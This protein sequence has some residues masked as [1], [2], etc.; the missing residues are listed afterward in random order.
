MGS[1][2]PFL[3]IPFVLFERVTLSIC[4]SL[5][6]AHKSLT[7]EGEQ[8]K[9]GGNRMTI[10]PEISVHSTGTKLIMTLFTNSVKS[11]RE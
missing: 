5:F 11:E 3:A 10:E 7:G 9:E 4:S 6:K 8:E 1:N 2:L